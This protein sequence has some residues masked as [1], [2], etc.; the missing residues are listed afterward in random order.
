MPRTARF[1]R[2]AI[3]CVIVFVSALPARAELTSP[4]T[5]PS[6]AYATVIRSV[7]PNVREAQSRAYAEALLA[8]AERLHVD[9]RLV[10]A[11]VTVES[12]WN[13]RAVSSS[14]ARGLG[15]FLPATA[16]DLGVDTRSARSTLRGVTTYLHQLLSMF[17]AS[18]NA[19]RE[20]IAGYNAG[21]FAVRTRGIPRY[22]ETPR[23]VAKVL[24][25]FHALQGR[26]CARPTPT[27]VIAVLDRTL[28]VER[29]QAAYWGSPP[30]R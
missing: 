29:V 10:M 21:P 6:S 18:R 25:T 22:G 28:A 30:L 23:Y 15:Q 14:G 27:Q 24:S 1:I 17:H 16:R 11:V 12:H 7:N 5:V 26:L 2:A 13:A 19:I 8:S 20:A 3:A 4:A 9:P